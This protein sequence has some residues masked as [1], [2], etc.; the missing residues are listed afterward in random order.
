MAGLQD[1]TGREGEKT[2]PGPRAADPAVCSPRPTPGA[3]LRAAV[4]VRPSPPGPGLPAVRPA[5]G[6]QFW[7]DRQGRGQGWRGVSP[8]AMQANPCPCHP[9]SH[10]QALTLPLQWA[11]VKVA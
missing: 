5:P 6:D 4:N 1:A 8:R 7:E 2:R 10:G 3:S 9:T 11:P